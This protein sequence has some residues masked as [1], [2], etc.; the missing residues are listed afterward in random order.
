M[1]FIDELILIKNNI[2]NISKIYIYA[3]CGIFFKNRNKINNI[4]KISYIEEMSGDML[5][6]EKINDN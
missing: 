3:S 2:S 5:V 6:L 1:N 4:Y